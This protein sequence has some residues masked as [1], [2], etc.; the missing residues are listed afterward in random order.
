MKG[1]EKVGLD[2]ISSEDLKQEGKK[3]IYKII[4]YAENFIIHTCN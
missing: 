3:Y 4:Q 1:N 2:K